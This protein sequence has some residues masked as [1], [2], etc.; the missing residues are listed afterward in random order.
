VQISFS[1]GKELFSSLKYV[2]GVK[3]CKKRRQQQHFV[4]LNCRY[5]FLPVEHILIFYFTAAKSSACPASLLF[6][7]YFKTASLK[8]MSIL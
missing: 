3:L 6:S 2:A 4:L 5:I 7:K 1:T 8:N